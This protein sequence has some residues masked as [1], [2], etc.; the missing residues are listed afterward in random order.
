MPIFADFDPG[1]LTG[2]YIVFLSG[3]SIGLFLLGS[4]VMLIVKQ[5]GA[6]RGFAIA[7]GI[8]L[9]L[10]IAGVLLDIFLVKVLH[11]QVL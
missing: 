9:C 11:W 4:V 8:V 5:A 3:V 1:T 2:F 6:A 10:G 7:A